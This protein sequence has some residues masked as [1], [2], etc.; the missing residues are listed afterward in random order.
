MS[1]HDRLIS[2]PLLRRQAAYSPR[3]TG[4]GEL[5][6]YEVQ[7]SVGPAYCIDLPSFQAESVARPGPADHL[8]HRLQLV[9]GIGP[10]TEAKLKSQGYSSLKRLCYHPRWGS[11]ARK[12]VRAI[13]EA[14]LVTLRMA[15]ARDRDLLCYFGT[16]DF[17]VV[18][19][20][21]TGLA[22]ALPV[23]L[24]GFACCENGAWRIRQFLARSFEEESAVLCLALETL[25]SRSALV[26]YNGRAFDEPY[27][28][29]RLA[30]H[31]MERPVFSLHFDLYQ[32]ARRLLHFL[33]DRRLP[34]VVKYALG[35]ERGDDIPGYMVPELFFRYAKEARPE[36]I[37]PVLRHN[38]RDVGDLCRLF[39]LARSVAVGQG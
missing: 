10:Y 15:G 25:G 11:A 9:Y 36:L 16:E 35:L 30:F 21:T 19:I 14:D 12:V 39:D 1:L 37:R 29:A 5:G 38:A 13:E 33:P 7:T 20:E 34:T 26:S 31:R 4:G 2:R 28:K 18:D 8:W 6:G 23:F 17:V 32:E 24:V 27:V 3:G 22:R